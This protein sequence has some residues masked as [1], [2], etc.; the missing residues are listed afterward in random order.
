[1]KEASIHGP[2]QIQ[3]EVFII[4]FFQLEQSDWNQGSGLDWN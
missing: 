3:Q 1:M 2:S 4:Q